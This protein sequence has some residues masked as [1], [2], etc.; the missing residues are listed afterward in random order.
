MSSQLTTKPI[1]YKMAIII[2]VAIYPL[3]FV[4]RSVFT[5]LGNPVPFQIQLAITLTMI[6]PFMVW[7]YLPWMQKTF[8][9]WLN[10]A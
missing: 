3:I 1:K 2:F 8:H 4:F 7:V 9:S 5:L 10:G 6:I